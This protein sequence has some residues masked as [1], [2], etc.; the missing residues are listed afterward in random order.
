MKIYINCVE[1]TMKNTRSSSRKTNENVSTSRKKEAKSMKKSGKKAGKKVGKVEKSFVKES[2]RPSAF[3]CNLAVVV[4]EIAKLKA[5]GDIKDC[6]IAAMMRTPFGCFFKAIFED[7]IIPDHV[8]MI[9]QV[10]RKIISGY[11]EKD[12]AFL[13][14]GEVVKLTPDDVSVTF[15]LPKHGK[16][17]SLQSAESVC[18]S[19]FMRRRFRGESS[20]KVSS[21]L[22]AVQST[23][24]EDGSEEDFARC[25]I[26][27]M[28]AT[29]FFANSNR[30]I[31]LSF[32]PCVENLDNIADVQWATII[33]EHLMRMVKKHHKDPFRTPGCV[34]Q[35]LVSS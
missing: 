12:D 31:A 20:L 6:H 27:Y 9:G 28:L 32:V 34:V 19:E 33:H 10:C 17:F 13:I 23:V 26:L 11:S 22:A 24:V 4:G 5:R 7:K 1:G 15:G 35:L 16:K 29:V 30:T 8:G 25:L 3:R 2:S 14:A 21:L 18:D